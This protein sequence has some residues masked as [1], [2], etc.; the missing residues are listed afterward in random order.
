[1]KPVLFLDFDGPLFSEIGIITG[2][3]ISEYPGKPLH[4]FIGYW[5]MDAK[6]V[7]ALN[8]FYDMYQ[9]DTVISS[10]WQRFVDKEQVEELFEINGL[11]L[12]I[13]DDWHTDKR[14]SYSSRVSHISDWLNTHQVLHKTVEDSD[15]EWVEAPSHIILDDPWSGSGLELWK[16]FGLQEPIMVDPNVGLNVEEYRAMHSIV[17]SWAGDYESRTYERVIP[18]FNNSFFDDRIGASLEDTQFPR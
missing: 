18:R 5:E 6:A 2:R 16:D 7:R 14:F 3:P 15:A 12:P 8:Q 17:Q 11:K 10:S 4:P 13:H 9:F 1:M